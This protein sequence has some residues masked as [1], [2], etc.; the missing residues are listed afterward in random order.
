MATTQALITVALA[1]LTLLLFGQFSV[2]SLVAN[3][4]AIPVVTWLVMPLALLGVLLAPL[5]DVAA[6]LVQWLSVGLTWL[7][8][9]GWAVVYR[10]VAPFWLA[11]AGV[12]G[13][14]LLVVRWPWL[15]RTAGALL[16][17]PALLWRPEPLAP[18]RF[19]VMAIDVGQGG[20]VLVRTAR[21]SLLYDTGPTHGPESNA[22][23]RV[24][25]P[26]LRTL[27][28]RLDVVVVSHSDSDH[29]GGSLAVEAAQPQAQWWSSF[30]PDPQRRCLAGQ[31]WEWDGVRFEFLHPHPE[32]FDEDGEGTLT[33]NA[34]S[35]VLMVSAGGHSA[36]LGGDIDDRQE[37]HMALSH[38][39]LRATLMLAPHHG[40]KSSSSPV[41]LNTLQPRW[42]VAQSGYRNR[43]N[44]PAPVVL[45]RYRQRGIPWV[46]SAS[47]GAATWQSWTPGE[48][49]CHRE[50]A[51]RFWHHPDPAYPV[52]PGDDPPDS[53]D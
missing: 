17:A 8:E 37:V 21:H 32:H 53:A 31:Q 38:P 30:D 13:G 45:R 42:I 44:H 48:L 1:P 35:C 50:T 23:D 2:A 14:V 22:G 19:E 16:L 24:V 43:F 3:L 29:S 25:V 36:W 5:W 39:E 51:R 41:L 40:S 33:T 9:G 46:T 6:W 34:M 52:Q 10:P 49:L 20:A 47:C 27:G 11:A 4:V 26:L 28:V 7:A 12:L 15:L 18:G